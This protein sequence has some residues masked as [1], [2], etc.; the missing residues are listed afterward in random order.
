MSFKSLILQLGKK[1]PYVRSVIEKYEGE[2]LDLRMALV[3]QAY[4][5]LR[6][7][8][9]Y[10]LQ[11]GWVMYPYRALSAPSEV[12][13][14][15]D[16][17]MRLPFVM[18]RDKKL[19]FPKSYS[20]AKCRQ[21]YYSLTQSDC[22]LGGKYMEKQPH[23]YQSE[24]F[25]IEKGDVLADVGCAEALLTLD[26]IDDVERAYLFEGDSKWMPA[27]QATFRDYMDK[28]VIINKFVANKDSNSTITLKTALKDVS[29][30]KVFIK[31]DI[32][33]A[34]VEVLKDSKGFL[35]SS[36]N[37]RLAC[38]TYH[39][40]ADADLM[41]ALYDEMG[42]QH[43]FSEGYMYFKAYDSRFLFPY[44]RHCVLRGWK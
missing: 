30:K 44:F 3:K 10:I 32:E 39:H 6:Q 12:K 18:H 29:D 37:I 35:S 2:I 1:L 21:S 4:P 36:Q 13:S 27:L 24:T 7:E 42:Y 43:E 26:K 31:M 23:Q 38:C 33:G 28:V 17:E 15:Y 11:N 40:Q 34:E 9:D 41:V 25:K 8:A 16:R 22:I 14:G 20:E 5:E 19:F